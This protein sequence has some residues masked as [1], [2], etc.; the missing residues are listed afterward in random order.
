MQNSSET[1]KV[2]ISNLSNITNLT[3]WYKSTDGIL[4]NAGRVTQWLDQS[5]SSFNLIQ[6]TDIRAEKGHICSTFVKMNTGALATILKFI[7][8]PPLLKSYNHN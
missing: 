3:G 6:N 2:I 8:N 7:S 5:N 4:L 1:R